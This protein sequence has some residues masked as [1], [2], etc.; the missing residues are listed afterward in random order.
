M[1]THDEWANALEKFSK[2]IRISPDAT[3][4]RILAMYGGMGSL[5]D[6][7]LYKNGQPSALE[8]IELDAL[9]SELYQLCHQIS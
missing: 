9:R 6:L 3:A 4:A 1:S 8:N 7:I 5:N 2:E